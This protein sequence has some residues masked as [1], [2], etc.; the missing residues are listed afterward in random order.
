MLNRVPYSCCTCLPL[1]APHPSPR[2]PAQML[3]QLLIDA[4]NQLQ[5]TPQIAEYCGQVPRLQIQ[6]TMQI[7]KFPSLRRRTPRGA[8]PSCDS[9]GSAGDGGIPVFC[10]ASVTPLQRSRQRTAA[11]M[12]SHTVSAR[13]AA[14]SLH[15][16]RQHA[17]PQPRCRIESCSAAASGKFPAA[18]YEDLARSVIVV[19]VHP[20]F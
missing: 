18:Q 6:V 4:I 1:R 3:A 17:R 15:W 20:D 5:R 10:L 8:H 14:T 9:F 7:S 19:P 12:F 16:Q 11:A 2:N 13:R